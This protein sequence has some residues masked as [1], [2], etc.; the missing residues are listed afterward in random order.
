MI[1]F[2]EIDQRLE[3]LG[4][5]RAWLAEVTGRS[6]GSIGSALAPNAAA[7]HRSRHLQRALT[8]AI[9]A[10]E[11]RR[12]TAS[13]PV[14][15]NLPD[16]ISIECTPEERRAWEEAALRERE[17]LERW[18]VNVLNTAAEADAASFPKS[19]GTEGV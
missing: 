15:P 12:A 18:A 10:E 5:E 6:P 2:D 14:V 19:N 4:L 11:L 1:P 8:D 3:K 13:A 7:K 17:T 16:R 9:E